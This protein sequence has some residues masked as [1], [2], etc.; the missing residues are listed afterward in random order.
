MRG[1]PRQGPPVVTRQITDREDILLTNRAPSLSFETAGPK[2][3]KIGQQ[4]TYRVTMLNTGD[5]DAQDVVVTVRLP[6]WAEVTG[7][8]TT[9]GSPQ[10]EPDANQSSVVHWRLSHLA[11]RGKEDLMLNIVPRDSRPFDLAVGWSFAPR[12][13]TAQIEVQEPK[14]EMSI[15][16]DEEVD[17]G[18]TAIYTITLSNPGNGDAEN[19]ILS[20]L[21]VTPTQDAAGTRNIGVVKAGERK[22]IELELTAHQAGRLQVKALARGE[23]GLRAEV[24]H[25]VLVRRASLTAVVIGPPRSFAGTVAIYKIRVENTGDAV[26]NDATA[27]ASVPAGAQY[28][29]SNDGG[30]F[31]SQTGHVQ[32]MVGPLRPGSV[33]VLE[34]QC[35]LE[36]AGD[37][38]VGFQVEAARDLRVSK[39]VVT[40]V[41][42]LADLKLY[43]NDPMGAIAVGE[44]SV[45]EVKI[46][47]RGTKAAEG[48]QV[49]GYFSNGIEPIN[50][51][52]W[53][54]D[55]S[56]GRVDF[57]PIEVL[58]AEQELV[59]RIT[60]R[61]HQPGDHV[62]RAQVECKSPETRLAVEDMTKYFGTSVASRQASGQQPL[63]SEDGASPPSD[64]D[65]RR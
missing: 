39:S 10:L 55:V 46:V 9:T 62:F 16:G 40:V 5:V 36:T 37:N 50:L 22:M 49:T 63:R 58:A 41:E 8:H 48:I 57:E 61:A 42:A 47:N 45:Y 30:K 20:L 1:V 32:W 29:S 17:Y 3:I 51:R 43:V 13:S 23:G 15:S 52:G 25:E 27:A 28:L 34:F 56:T 35:V 4:A 60:A 65:L 53:R 12:Q 54:G 2:R 59:F 26:A 21:P 7:S 6:A 44:D 31:D 33:R 14:L 11:S 24:S 19:V 38:R 64:L 18:Q